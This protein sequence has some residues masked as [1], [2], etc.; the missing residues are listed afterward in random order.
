MARI[1]SPL[2]RISA[3]V[4][5]RGRDRLR[6]TDWWAVLVEIMVVV[7]G[8]LIAFELQAWGN[9]RERHRNERALLQRIEEEAKGDY[10][11]V[12][13]IWQQHRESADNYRLLAR[14]VTDPRAEAE[15]HR[16]GASGCNLLRLPAVRYA[17]AG[18]GALGAG[19][20][21]ELISD[22]ELRDRLRQADAER[23]F[24]ESQLATFRDGFD[25]YAPLIEPHMQWAFTPNEVACGV[26]IDSLRSDPQAIALLPKLSRDQ[27]RFANYRAREGAST[28]AVLERV[29]CLRHDRCE[30]VE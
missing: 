18:S 5:S 21:L 30:A 28:F 16:R 14:A 26:N 25:R 12:R 4:A 22:R 8:I 9:N 24:A 7:L 13:R 20:R 23:V 6:S 1:I 27:K 19:E 10:L 17:S 15:Y 3:A 11:A 2:Q 29:R